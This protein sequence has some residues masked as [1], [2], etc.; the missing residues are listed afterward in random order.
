MFKSKN[1]KTQSRKLL[2]LYHYRYLHSSNK[3]TNTS[4]SLVCFETICYFTFL[5]KKNFTH[6]ILYFSECVEQLLYFFFLHRLQSDLLSLRF[7]VSTYT[8]S[9]ICNH[10]RYYLGDRV[11]SC[12][13]REFL[14]PYKYLKYWWRLIAPYI[15]PINITMLNV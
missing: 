3:K 14:L 7:D 15:K 5:V 13:S 11:R 1:L 4:Q 12:P 10:R 8:Y 6:L 2:L 9:K